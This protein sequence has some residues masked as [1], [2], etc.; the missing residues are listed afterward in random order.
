MTQLQTNISKVTIFR[1]GARVT[2]IGKLHLGKGARKLVVEGITD[3]ADTNSFRVKGKGPAKLSSI[4]V[5]YISEVFEPTEDMKPLHNELKELQKK[6]QEL[7]DDIE[8]QNTRLGNL[9]MMM[10]EFSNYFGLVYAA[11]EGDISQLSEMD[12]KSSKMTF[13]TQTNK[14]DLEDELEEIRKK[15]EVLRK[16]IGRIN[17]ERRTETSVNVEISLEVSEESDI[18]IEVTYQV[19]NARWH[20]TYDVDLL[21][22]KTKLR[23]MAQLYNGTEEDWEKVSLTVSTATARPVVAVEGTPYYVGVYSPEMERTRSDDR[24]MKKEAPRP[25]AKAMLSSAPPAPPPEIEEEFAEATETVS[26]IVV[27]EI[28]KPMTIPSDNEKHPVT[29]VEEELDS[30]TIHYWYADGMAEVV[31]QDKVTNKDN[32][33]LPGKMKV[34]AEGEYIGE[35]SIEQISPREAFK[36]GTRSAYDVKAEKKLVHREV[37][38]AGVMRGKL[39]RS[40]KYRL[41][42]ENFSKYPVEIDVFDRIPHS[43]STAIEVKSYWEKVG[44]EKE[45]LGIVEW[46]R[47]IQPNEKTAIEYEYEVA[48]EKEVTIHPR[49][50]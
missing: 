20:P 14:R 38:K 1:D 31:A 15:I 26:G 43:V 49:L 50:P 34:Y 9:E 17:S 32:V 45:N 47:I 16:N 8:F 24:K 22:K 42:I 44:I 7:V 25:A 29:L 5:R 6:E 3:H 37:E 33:I 21:L 39:R 2:R 28:Q 40:Y 41:E 11:N 13:D 36:I 10:Q 30:T 23:R 4:D 35:T 46:H 48:W 19:N 27:Y 18:E 12:K